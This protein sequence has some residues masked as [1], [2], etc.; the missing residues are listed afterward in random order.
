[1]I[2]NDDC[3]QMSAWYILST[4]GF[5]PVNSSNGEFVFGSPQ[6]K[7][8]VIHLDNGKEFRIDSYNF[9]NETIFN[10]NRFLNE[11]K[12]AKPFITYR[13]IRA[14]GTLKF[15]MINN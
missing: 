14:G 10:E 11:R 8:A 2:G 15:E 13:E 5:Y 1:M 7:K 12:I 3:G 6:V 9:S 4:L